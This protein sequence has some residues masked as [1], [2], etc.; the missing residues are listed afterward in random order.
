MRAQNAFFRIQGI[1]ILDN[2]LFVDDHYLISKKLIFPIFVTLRQMGVKLHFTPARYG[3]F[4]ALYTYFNENFVFTRK[5]QLH[6]SEEPNIFTILK[7]VTRL[8]L[9]RVSYRNFYALLTSFFHIRTCI[10]K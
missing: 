1:K 3:Y 6:C 7:N 4:H 2:L 5:T 8:I 9:L 10:H